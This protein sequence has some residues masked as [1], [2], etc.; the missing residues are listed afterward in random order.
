[1]S[2]EY[3]NEEEK[4]GEFEL[5]DQSDCLSVLVQLENGT[6]IRLQEQKKGDF[7]IAVS[8]GFAHKK[9]FKTASSFGNLIFSPQADLKES[10]SGLIP[11]VA[12]FLISF[13]GVVECL[14]SGPP[15]KR[16]SLRDLLGDDT[17]LTG[18]TIIWGNSTVSPIDISTL[19]AATPKKGILTLEEAIYPMERLRRKD[20]KNQCDRI[21][22]DPSKMNRGEGEN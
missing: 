1:M 7:S 16:R 10:S 12:Q 21:F 13:R 22:K 20:V 4:S 19:I 18:K 17:S 2:E 9:R 15:V 14:I 5:P 11:L 6:I 3:M 8:Q